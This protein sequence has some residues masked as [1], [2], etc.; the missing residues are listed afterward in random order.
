[1]RQRSRQVP[2][3]GMKAVTTHDNPSSAIPLILPL[4]SLLGTSCH[5]Q[6]SQ[7]CHG[8]LLHGSGHGKT[9]LAKAFCFNR[10]KVVTVEPAD[11]MDRT[12][13][14]KLHGNFLGARRASSL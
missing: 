13:S 1:M 10:N 2:G 12:G 7:L 3:V 4:L 14:L 9:H 5:P 6:P 8:G 11:K